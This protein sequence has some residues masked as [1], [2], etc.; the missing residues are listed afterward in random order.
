[1]RHRLF[2]LAPVVFGQDFKVGLWAW[3]LCGCFEA[4]CNRFQI[5]AQAIQFTRRGAG[6]NLCKSHVR[7]SP[8]ADF[9]LRVAT[10]H[11]FVCPYKD[12]CEL[13]VSGLSYQRFQGAKNGQQFAR[14][15]VQFVNLMCGG[16]SANHDDRIGGLLEDSS[17]KNNL[18]YA[19][20]SR[21]FVSRPVC[22]AGCVNSGP[23]SS[24]NGRDRADRLHPRCPL[25]RVQREGPTEKNQIERSPDSYLGR[26]Q[27]RRAQPSEKSCHSGIL[28]C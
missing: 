12:S 9:R 14:L 20:L 3:W 23:D 15:V 13:S 17:R 4:S 25:A 21:V 27:K 7:K 1:M 10:R 24:K 5:F 26:Q 6:G 19:S 2:G 16:A 8:L 28:S 22:A 18:R 11:R